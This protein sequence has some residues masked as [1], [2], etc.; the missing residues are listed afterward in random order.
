MCRYAL[1]DVNMRRVPLG[2]AP[3]SGNRSL[4]AAQAFKRQLRSVLPAAEG[5]SLLTVAQHGSVWVEAVC[6]AQT[7]GAEAW[8]E[9]AA[10]LA[11]AVWATIA[12]R[13]KERGR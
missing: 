3:G 9:R 1:R 8:A 5:A 12:E 7:P 10:E 2:V 13:R 6:D 11:P 4:D